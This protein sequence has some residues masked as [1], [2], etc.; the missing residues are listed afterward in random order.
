MPILVGFRSNKVQAGKMQIFPLKKYSSLFAGLQ[1]CLI[2]IYNKADTKLLPKL[3]V[4]R[5]LNPTLEELKLQGVLKEGESFTV[6]ED[7]GCPAHLDPLEQENFLEES[8]T[9]RWANVKTHVNA[10]GKTSVPDLIQL[11][12]MIKKPTDFLN[13]L[14][15]IQYKAYVTEMT[16]LLEKALKPFFPAKKKLDRFIEAMALLFKVTLPS[17][18]EFNIQEEWRRL[19][20]FP[21]SLENCLSKCTTVISDQTLDDIRKALPEWVEEFITAGRLSDASL[22]A[23][24]GENPDEVDLDDV[25]L[26]SERVVVLSHERTYARFIERKNRPI[27]EAKKRLDEIA[28]KKKA[29]EEAAEK[30]KKERESAREEKRVSVR[31]YIHTST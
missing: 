24:L 22:N 21:L 19:G 9:A 13:K 30:K 3:F 18:T 16:L 27:V 12:K 1:P 25:A 6:F 20:L 31:I 2:V 10:T 17:L 5:I 8:R 29:S 7:G 26:R 28:E 14:T 23:V 15:Q 4:N 11:F